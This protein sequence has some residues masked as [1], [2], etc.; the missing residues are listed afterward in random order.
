MVNGYVYIGAKGGAKS[1]LYCLKAAEGD[2][3]S[4]PMFKYNAA[5]TGAK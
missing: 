5:R 2:T 3:G 1:A 4:W